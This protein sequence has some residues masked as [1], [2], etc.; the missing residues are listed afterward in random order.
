MNKRVLLLSVIFIFAGC[1]H[2]RDIK[3]FQVTFKRTVEFHT[4]Y[5]MASAGGIQGL[6]ETDLRELIII[7]EYISSLEKEF[8]ENSEQ[9]LSFTNQKLIH[10]DKHFEKVLFSFI[11]KLL[12]SNCTVTVLLNQ[13][14][15]EWFMSLKVKSEEKTVTYTDIPV[16]TPSF[17]LYID[18]IN[19]SLQTVHPEDREANAGL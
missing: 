9:S 14:E 16:K 18:N 17:W 5:T 3:D 19:S 2:Y 1:S 8:M 6:D 13:T 15:E 7:N 11:V 4:V 12:N 10:D